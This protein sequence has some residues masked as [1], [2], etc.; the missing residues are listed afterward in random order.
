MTEYQETS[1]LLEE[2]SNVIIS[3]ESDMSDINDI[4]R[5]LNTLVHN[6][7]AELDT[8]E[9]HMGKTYK[10]V[11]SGKVHLKKASQYQSSGRRIMCYLLLLLIIVMLIVIIVIVVQE[12]S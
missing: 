9:S 3:I 4:V 10:H 5:S 7:G 6:Q 1:K 2:R 12:K 11:V 8:I